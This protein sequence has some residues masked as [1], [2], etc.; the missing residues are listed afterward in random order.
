[1]LTHRRQAE[2]KVQTASTATDLPHGDW[3]A[4]LLSVVVVALRE[5]PLQT[6]TNPRWPPSGHSTQP[7]LVEDL[8]LPPEKTTNQTPSLSNTE[9]EK[10]QTLVLKCSNPR[11]CTDEQGYAEHT[12]HTKKARCSPPQNC[13]RNHETQNIRLFRFGRANINYVIL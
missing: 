5:T 7:K 13:T 8:R 11:Q 4:P 10:P 2:L 9:E 12:M 1:M 3:P 6:A